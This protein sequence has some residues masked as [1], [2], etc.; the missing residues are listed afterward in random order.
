MERQTKL[1]MLLNPLTTENVFMAIQ[2]IRGN[3]VRSVLTI[4]IIAVG[5]TALVGILTAIDSIKNSI[6]AEFTRLGANTFTIQSRGMRVQVG[7]N[8]YRSKNY[9]YISYFQAQEFKKQFDFPADV[10]I[11]VFATGTATIRY[12]SQKSNP[13]VRVIGVD[14]NYLQTAGYDISKGRNFASQEI[15]S[16][17]NVA[18]LGNGLARKLFPGIVN[19]TGR[20]ISIG[21]ARYRVVGVLAEKGSGFGASG[22]R[23]V[24]LPYSNVRQVFSRLQMNFQIEV[25]PKSPQLLDIA[26]GEAEGVFRVV[27]GLSVTDESDFNIVKSDNL[28]NILLENIK[29]I[30]LA[31]T[32]IGFITLLGAA[33][34]LMNIMLVTV[35]ERTREIGV[36]KA[37]GANSR[38]IR[39]QF[40]IES[41]VIGQLGGL[42]GIVLGILAG[43]G[44]SALV[45]SS[46][47]VPWLWIFS[48]VAL[49]LFV[50]LVSGLMP[51]MQAAKLDPIE[52][53]RYE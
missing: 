46:F 44:V 17:S 51:A 9:S 23:L 7:G 28:V 45:G 48:G 37:M 35:S 32:I 22:D 8:R 41:I 11:S 24:L 50:S 47:I 1:L 21:T 53:L 29:Y 26:V 42:L 36:R 25:M 19:P 31:A 49:C 12:E 15:H 43:N 33:V 39:Q 4:L 2:S 20:I 16:G 14:G 40:L 52:S 34:G 27:R 30:T 13:N 6:T 3:W 38:T 18:L 5:I 10:S